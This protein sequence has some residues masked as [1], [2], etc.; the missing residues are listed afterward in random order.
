MPEEINE[1]VVEELMKI[2]GEARGVHL[3]NDGDFVLKEKGKEGIEKLEKEL[4][5]L[6]CPIKY[7]EINQFDFYPAGMRI[8]SLLAIKKTFGWP[9]EKIEELGAYAMQVSWIIKLF[10]KYF[11]SVEK[12]FKEAP[13]IWSKYFTIGEVEVGEYDP[14]KNCADLKFKNF[15]LHPVYCHCL[16]GVLLGVVKMI[17]KSEKITCE[18]IECPFK[19][20]KDHKFLI[21][22]Q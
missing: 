12:T 8:I 16:K 1:E 21:K 20:G 15:N 9:D 13:K 18:E 5:K 4:E 3:K 10:T 14:K 17:I 22:W 11:F 19:G 7:G 6:G 2:K